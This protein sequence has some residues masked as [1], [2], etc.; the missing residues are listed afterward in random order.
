MNA[1]AQT[2]NFNRTAPNHAMIK[3]GSGNAGIYVYQEF[4]EGR[5][6]HIVEKHTTIT[7]EADTC[8]RLM[9]IKNPLLRGIFPEIY[10]L[11]TTKSPQIIYMEFLEGVDSP[12]LRGECSDD[13]ITTNAASA[14]AHA[15]RSLE[16]VGS[17]HVCVS[18]KPSRNSLLKEIN[19][20]AL[21]SN[22]A[23]MARYRSELARI[24]EAIAKLVHH[25]NITLQH[26]D[27]KPENLAIADDTV[28]FIDL[29][30]LRPHIQ[31]ACFRSYYS[32]VK[33]GRLAASFYNSLIALYCRAA[34]KDERLIRVSSICR[35]LSS[36]LT[37]LRK[38]PTQKDQLSVKHDEFIRGCIIDLRSYLL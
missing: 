21:A 8:R 35:C 25:S 37:E 6:R 16:K 17:H 9:A 22:F 33:R 26:N 7:N 32:M 19:L 10:R 20:E 31:G 38:S 2:H 28:K 14:I 24:D 27:M 11:N 3:G 23:S 15:V 29:A 12:L 30:A 13:S 5:Y 18:S 34:N 4:F 1:A 36:L